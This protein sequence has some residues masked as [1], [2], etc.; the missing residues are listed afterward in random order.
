MM[1]RKRKTNVTPIGKAN[2]IPVEIA[3][4]SR[5]TA[6]QLMFNHLEGVETA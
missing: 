2:R 5:L 3:D 1:L 4:R 6:L